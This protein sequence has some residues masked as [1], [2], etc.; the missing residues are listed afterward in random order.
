MSDRNK[1]DGSLAQRNAELNHRDYQNSDFDQKGPKTFSEESYGVTRNGKDSGNVSEESFTPRKY[2]PPHCR[3]RQ[4]RAE[5]RIAERDVSGNNENTTNTRYTRDVPLKSSGSKE[6]G[7]W[8]RNRSYRDGGHASSRDSSD[9]RGGGYRS[10]DYGSGSG[11]WAGDSNSNGYTRSRVTVGPSSG[12]GW[13]GTSRQVSSEEPNPFET[14]DQSTDKSVKIDFDKYDEIPVETSGHDCPR[15]IESWSEINLGSL[16]QE[17][18]RLAR[19][20]RPTPV[21]KYSLP[22]VMSGRDLMGCAQTGSGKTAAFLF[23][24][25]SVLCGHDYYGNNAAVELSRRKVFPLSLILAPTRELACQI[26]DEAR[27]FSYRTGLRTCV[28]YGGEPIGSQLRDLERGCDVLVATPGRL[29]DILE[30]GRISLSRVRYLVLDE[31]DRMLDMGFEPQIRR[32]VENED[33]PY[34]GERQTLMFSATFPKEIQLLASSFLHDY[35]FLAVGRVGSTTDLVTQKFIQVDEHDK[36]Y[37]LLDLL[38]SVK[39]LTLIFVETKKKADMLENFLLGENFPATSIHGDRIQQDRTAALR[40]FS[41]GQTP[42]LI[43][44]NVAA[45]GLDIENISHVINYDMPSDIDDYV[46]RIGRTG[47]AGKPG[48]ATALISEENT[49]IVSKLLELLNESGQEVPSWLEALRSHHSASTFG[50]SSYRSGSNAY[51]GGHHGSSGSGGRRGSRFGG[52]DYRQSSRDRKDLERERE[53]VGTAS[54]SGG[55]SVWF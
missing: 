53:R 49:N 14:R 16:L 23:P 12:I 37:I 35:I 41:T 30:R 27:K 9:S 11:G 28:V 1:N 20:D 22:I 54:N 18:I 4:D 43:A 40:A 6:F 13:R 48:L 8:D 34:I 7:N 55:A 32:I 3:N 10:R 39:G 15:P 44:T 36:Q 29:V 33:M 21:Q 5:T 24:M 38:G 45:R 42:Y 17:N 50:A 46:H 47:R 25:I 31:A 26:F 51:H 2:V 52:R 19:Y